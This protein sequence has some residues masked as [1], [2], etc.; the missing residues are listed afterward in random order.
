MFEGRRSGALYV[1]AGLL[2]AGAVAF[3]VGQRWERHRPRPVP[4]MVLAVS[5]RPAHF[6]LAI[7]PNHRYLVDADGTPFLI[8]GDAAWSLISDPTR[9]EVEVYLA[10]RAARGFNTILVNLLEHRFARH[11]PANAYGDAPFGAVPFEEPNARYFDHAHWVI[12]RARAHGMLVL[13]APAYLGWHGE[14]DGWWREMKSAGADRLSAYGRFVGERF[15]QDDNIVWVNAGDYDPPDKSLVRAVSRGIESAAPGRLQT[16]HIAP[17]TPLRDFWRGDDDW[18][19]VLAVYTYHD[20]C[21]RTL[22]A[23]RAA[24]PRPSFLIESFYEHENGAEA[25]RVRAQAYDALLC[26]AAG[27]VMG[28]NPVWHFSDAGLYPAPGNWWQ[29]LGSDGARSM[30]HLANIF[31][32][33]PWWRLEPDIEARLLV[34]G[35]AS[36]DPTERTVAARTADGTL[37]LVYLPTAR[38]VTIDFRQIRAPAEAFW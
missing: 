20:V 3:L 24:D 35:T 19:D 38:Q 22:E 16:A 21:A 7:G 33:L 8:Q 34:N 1:C 5:P 25:W 18:L 10:D 37:A 28:N 13:L 26:G 11:A 2:V 9:E 12:E 29:N 31:S 27:Q 32:G 23:N 6:P 4:D 15:A 30:T 36:A 14:A 17:E